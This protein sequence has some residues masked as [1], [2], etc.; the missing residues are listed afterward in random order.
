M[1]RNETKLEEGAYVGIQDRAGIVCTEGGGPLGTNR[2]VADPKEPRVPLRKMRVAAAS[3]GLH[4]PQLS[5]GW[6]QTLQPLPDP[7]RRTLS[8]GRSTKSF[9]TICQKDFPFL[10]SAI[11]SSKLH[12]H[13]HLRTVYSSEKAKLSFSPS[14][15]ITSHCLMLVSRSHTQS[16]KH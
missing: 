12:K 3:W 14:P 9:P 13:F 7:H 6:G 8:L 16:S 2:A 11:Y 10:S 1:R 5:Q 15:N 4:G